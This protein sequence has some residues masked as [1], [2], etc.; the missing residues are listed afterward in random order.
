MRQRGWW[1]SLALLAYRGEAIAGLGSAPT[2]TCGG[3]RRNAL[4]RPHPQEQGLVARAFRPAGVRRGI[5]PTRPAAGHQG[6]A[7]HAVG[8]R[9]YCDCGQDHIAAV[10]LVSTLRR[11]DLY[12][13]GPG[14]RC[15]PAAASWGPEP[16]SGGQSHSCATAL[17]NPCRFPGLSARHMEDN[18]GVPEHAPGSGAGMSSVCT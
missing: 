12:P 15:R 17:P 10:V 3:L 4:T 9:P 5:A 16:L 2:S 8:V 13:Q 1:R 6:P 14:R 7:F 11:H 18:S